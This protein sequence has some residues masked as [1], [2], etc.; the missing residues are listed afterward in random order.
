[1]GKLKSLAADTVVYGFSTILGRLL[2]WLLTP[3]Y[4]RTIA[5]SD[6]GVVVNIYSIIAVLLVVGTLGFE[7]GYFRY[8]SNKNRDSLFDS[9]SAGV[10]M[11][12]VII[13]LLMHFFRNSISNWFEIPGLAGNI[14]LVTGLI[15][16]VDSLNAIPFAQLRF[17]NKSIKYAVLRLVQ[18]IV[19]VLFNIVF[20]VLLRD[21]QLL[22][23]DFSSQYSVYNI[24]LANFLGSF[25]ITLYFLPRFIKTHYQFDFS[26]FKQVFNYSLPLVGMG[27][28]GMLNQNIEKI[29]L[30]KLVKDQDA[31]KSLA[32]YGANYKIGVLMAIFTQSFRMAF[33]PFFF[34]EF[35]DNTDTDVYGKALK[36]FALFGL[37]IYAGVLLFLPMVNHLLTPEYYEG[38]KI[39]PFILLGQ[40][41]FGIYYSFSIWYKVTDRTYYGILMSLAGLI[42]N[43]VLN[44]VLVPVIGYM[45]AAISTFVGYSL[46]MALSYFLG[47]H[48]YPIKYPICKILGYSLIVVSLVMVNGWLISQYS[49]LWFLISSMMFMIIIGIIAIFEKNDFKILISNVRRKCLHSQ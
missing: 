14:M 45:G 48:Y 10:L 24:L 1:M 28:F 19:T 27:L 3:F 25:V 39:I 30:I 13:T 4:I 15:I 8:I 20:L 17:E 37:V 44:I 38:N 22:G 18:V 32:I 6:F 41:F 42:V 47:N 5:Q 33:E 7:T 21:K 49:S 26:L 31:Y 36:Y 11:C 43:T 35:K 9:L 46:M 2:N 34:K 23:L 29:I 40:L 16:L 12:G